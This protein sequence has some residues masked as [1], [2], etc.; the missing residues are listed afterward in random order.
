MACLVFVPDGIVVVCKLCDEDAEALQADTINRMPGELGQKGD[1]SLDWSQVNYR[2]HLETD[3]MS[4][5]N[6][7]WE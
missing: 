3:K 5:S 4:Y 1:L 7:N 6:S 2:A